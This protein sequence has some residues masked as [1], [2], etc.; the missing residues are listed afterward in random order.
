[1]NEGRRRVAGRT[2]GAVSAKRGCFLFGTRPAH[3][4]ERTPEPWPKGDHPE[5]AAVKKRRR[6]PPFG[7]GFGQL[8]MSMDVDQCQAR[9]G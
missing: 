5:E 3:E 7:F 4:P 1:M 6:R 8:E 2:G 9:Q